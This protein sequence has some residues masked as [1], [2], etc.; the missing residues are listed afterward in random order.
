MTLDYAKMTVAEIKNL[1]ITE[2]RFTKEELDNLD[3]KG[4]TAWV[5]LHTGESEPEL[6]SEESYALEDLGAEL[7]ELLDEVETQAM[8]VTLMQD[9]DKV[10]ERDYPDYN[11]VE[12]NDWVMAQFDKSELMDGKYPNVNGLR[13]LV[14][15]LLGDIV[16]SGPIE[17]HNID[18]GTPFGK[19]YVVYRID[20]EWK[21]DSYP[22]TAGINIHQEYPVRTFTST[23]GACEGNMDGVFMAFPE[24]MAD[25]RAEVRT[26][27]RALRINTVGAE[28]LTKKD[29]GA[30]L[31]QK[32]DQQNMAQSSKGE[33]SEEDLITDQQINTITIICERLGIDLTKFI[34]SGQKTYKDVRDVTRAAAAGMVKQLNRYQ[35]SGDDSI[36]IPQN[37]LIG[38]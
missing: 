2:G 9:D 37:L 10:V 4:K 15:R 12:W 8:E 6:E 29:I 16:F 26:L 7:G 24:A 27:R 30:Y 14:G 38:D 1:L 19:T 20:I 22:S 11:D 13:R 32:Q 17:V 23:A 28:E 18:D 31:K 21:L 5:Q 34:N 36:S 25:T 3:I 33:W 35:N